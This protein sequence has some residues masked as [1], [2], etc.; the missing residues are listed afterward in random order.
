[1]RASAGLASVCILG[2]FAMLWVAGCSLL[3][4]D[5]DRLTIRRLTSDNVRKALAVDTAVN[6]YLAREDGDEGSLAAVLHSNF[7]AASN[8]LERVPELSSVLRANSISARDYLNTIGSIKYAEMLS[9]VSAAQNHDATAPGIARTNIEFW[10]S[11]PADLKPIA[12]DWAKSL[13]RASPRPTGP[14]RQQVLPPARLLG[15]DRV[16]ATG[17]LPLFDR[18]K[19]QEPIIGNMRAM[20]GGGRPVAADKRVQVE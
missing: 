16:E 11:L 8:T 1:M 14:S 7:V 9:G 18:S 19:Q 12:E 10:K 3:D 13:K 6:D 20:D 5:K 4:G 17:H 2:A 15:H